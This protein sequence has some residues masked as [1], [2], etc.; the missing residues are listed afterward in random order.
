M[1]FLEPEYAQNIVVGVIFQR[2]F[3]WY[4]TDKE[5]WYLDYPKFDR[6]SQASGPPKTYPNDSY[7]FGIPVLNETTAE[8]FL[9]R[10]ANHRIPAA[11]LSQMMTFWTLPHAY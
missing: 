10:I 6:A 2:T 8:R 5:Y 1:T 9:A 4:V 3:A 7:R 11:V